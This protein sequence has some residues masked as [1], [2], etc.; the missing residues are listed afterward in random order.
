MAKLLGAG[1][2][3]G[4]SSCPAMTPGQACQRDGCH[5]TRQSGKVKGSPKL[6]QWLAGPW[7]GRGPAQSSRCRTQMR[8]WL[9]P[10]TPRLARVR[11]GSAPGLW[12]GS[13][14]EWGLQTAWAGIWPES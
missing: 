10:R 12:I 14:G 7:G 9:G 2:G 5:I 6:L 4:L 3:Q 8:R 1:H 13:G 11:W